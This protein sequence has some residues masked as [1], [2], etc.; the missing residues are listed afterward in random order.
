MAK[1]VRP[2]ARRTDQKPGGSDRQPVSRSVVA[3]TQNPLAPKSVSLT[4]APDAQGVALFQQAVEALQRKR[5]GVAAEGFRRL[6]KQFP[7][8]RALLDRTR[9]Y[10]DLAERELNRQP[11]NPRTLEERVTAA[12]A[13]LNNEQDAEAERLV[14][15]VLAEDARHDLALYLMAAIEARRGEAEAALACLGRAIA[16]SPEVRAQAR[17]DADFERLRSSDAFQ[18]LVDPPAS[19]SGPRKPRRGHRV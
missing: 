8:E 2:K 17:H 5:Y 14:R 1:R 9:V 4:Q 6:L 12:T 18:T 3:S 11:A 16:I 10:L 7:T 13:A 15:S 19:A